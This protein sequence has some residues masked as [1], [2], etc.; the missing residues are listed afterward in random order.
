MN[1]ENIQMDDLVSDISK[2]RKEFCNDLNMLDV[3]IEYSYKMNIDLE[4]LGY[5]LAEH[6]QFKEILE[7]ELIKGKYMKDTDNLPSI[8]ESEY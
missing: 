5:V 7:I 8:D 2:F 4:Q 3:L 6:E 1:I